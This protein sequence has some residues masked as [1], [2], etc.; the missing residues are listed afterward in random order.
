MTD[1]IRGIIHH[2]PKWLSRLACVPLWKFLVHALMNEETEA[3][4]N[5]T[6]APGEGERRAQRGYV[7]QYDLAAQVI[8]EA[9]AAGRLQWVGVADRKAGIFDDVVL[10]L[11]DRI[12]AHQVKTS[13]D[14]EPFNIKTIM[15]GAENLWARMLETRRKLSAGYPDAIIETIY[16]CDD[17]PRTNDNLSAANAPSS[18]AAFI[19]THQAYRLAWTLADWRASHFAGF[20]GELQAASKLSDDAF[21]NVWRN[22]RFLV[23]GQGRSI[24]IP[25]LGS[26]DTR[27]LRELAAL[28]PRLVADRA[29]QDRWL[30]SEILDRLGW[31]DPFDL[32]HGHAFPVD[33]LYQTNATTEDHLQ[34]ILAANTSGYTSLIGPPG[35]GKSTLLASGLL[36][37]PR[38]VVVR[39]LA[40]VPGEG[41]GLGRAEAFDFLN[42][43]VKQ[44]KQQNLGARVVP[45]TE[46]V[47]LREQFEAILL[48]AGERFR[49][50]GIRTVVVVDGLDH[51]PR[52]ERPQR[53]FLQEL[54]L[55]HAVPEGI[56]FVLG[57]QRLDLQDVPPAVI[58]QAGKNGR[59][60]DISPL[61][62]EVVSRLADAAGVPQDVDRG[63]LYTQTDGHPLST[64]YVIEG[65]LN[66]RTPEGREDWLRNGPAYGGDIETFY[67]RAWHDLEQNVAGQRALAY[68]ALAEGPLSTNS[69][70]GIVGARATDDAWQAAK[71]LLVRDHQGG[72][73]IFH[74]SFRLFLR[75]RTGLRHG[76]ADEA[77]VRRRYGELADMARDANQTDSQRW[78]ELRYRARAG[79]HAAVAELARPERFRTQFI[80]GR[81]PGDIRIDIDFG[82]EAARF[83]RRPE[84]VVD[85]VLSRHEINMRAEALGD[86]VFEVLIRLGERRAALGLLDA[87]GVSLTVGKGYELVDAFLN[88]GE[89]P[90]ARKLFHELEPIHKLLGSEALEMRVDDNDLVEWAERALV[91]REPRQFLASIA[92]LRARDEPFGE[93]FDIEDYRTQLKLIAVRGQ[94]MRN[95]ELA[96]EQLREALQIGSEN[97]GLLLYFAAKAAFDGDNDTVALQRLKEGFAHL[98]D[99][100]PNVKQ[101]LAAFAA[102]IGKLDL[103]EAFFVDAPPP[104]LAGRDIAYDVE[105][106]RRVSRQIIT[107]ATLTAWLGRPPTTGDTPQ[108]RLLATYQMRLETIG[109]LLGEGRAGCQPSLEPMQEFRAT[110][111][112]LQRA[113]GDTPHDSER[114]RLDQIMDEMV[115]A[116]VDAAVA[117]GSD[118]FARFTEAMD[119]RLAA[120]AGRLGRSTVRRA[121]AMAAFRHE[122]D[123]GRAELRLAYRACMERTPAE[124]LTEAARTASAFATFGL[125]NRARALVAE[126]H[127]DGL[128]YARPAKKDAQYLVWRDLL[129]RAG[130]E[131]PAGRPDRLRFFGRMLAG[132]AD[133]E[134]DN[135]GS[136]LATTF[137]SEAAQEGPA[138]AKAAA[139]R[140]EEC[141]LITWTDL[142]RGLVSGVVKSRPDLTAAAGV[143]FGRTALPFGGEYSKSIYPA[144]ILAAPDEQ[145]ETVVRHAATCIEVD[146]HTTR[147]IICL[148]EVVTAAAARGFDH[149]AEA[150]AR[151][152]AEL[153]PPRSGDSPEDPF[154]LVRTLEGITETLRQVGEK[155]TTYGA[156]RAFQRI[157]PRSD[158]E[159]AK[160]V[161]DRAEVLSADERSIETMAAAA[162]AAGRQQDARTY[163]QNLKQLA[164]ER[165]SWGDGW[166]GGAKQRYHRLNV[167][168]NGDVARRAA[169]DAFVEDLANRREF[170]DYILPDLGNVLELLSPRPTWAETWARLQEHLS[171]FR[172]HRMGDDLEPGI[173]V[174]EGDEHTLADILFRAIDTTSVELTHMARTAAIELSHMPGG[175]AVVA[176]L[177]P[178]LWRAGGYCSLEASQV[179][180][181]CR[182]VISV[183]DAVM[184]FLGEMCDNDDFAIRRL[185]M[186][187]AHGWGQQP[188][189]KRGDLPVIY[190]LELLPNPEAERFEP[191]SGISAT[192][193][194]LYTEDPYSWTWPLED[195]LKITARATGLDLANL[196]MRAAQLMTRMG[197]AVAF[198]PE[199]FALQQSRLRRLSL[200][201]SYR[202]LS[203]SAAFQAMR[204]LVGELFAADA[205][206]PRAIPV[207]LLR[208]AAF[209]R[210]IS[211]LPPAP[212]P[213]GVPAP[214]I[215]DIHASSA[216][217]EWVAQADEDAVKPTVAGNVVLA[218]T[219]IHV[220]RNFRDEWIVEQY[221]GPDT[222]R[223]EEDLFRQLR[224]LP[225]VVVADGAVPMYEGFAPG[226]V[227]HP[228]PVMVG[229]VDL[230]MVMLCPRVAAALGWRPDPRHAFTYFDKSDQVV[231]RTIYWR[232]G[233]ERSR[234]SDADV[235]RYGFVL[236]AREDEAERIR[237]YLSKAQ[238][239]RAWRRTQ[240]NGSEGRSAACG[241]RFETA[242]SSGS[243]AERYAGQRGRCTIPPFTCLST[244]EPYVSSAVVAL[245]R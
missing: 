122:F 52:E 10:G 110:L 232:D 44:L 170:V 106:I 58:D 14:P 2:R 163:L 113:E 131:D 100:P 1:A 198:G 173:G 120:G 207:I 68:V 49:A 129:V 83:L 24:G 60:V 187:L 6:V 204:E 211:T 169:F 99:L 243:A 13:R 19:R 188:R 124:Q 132:L 93:G 138:W 225:R 153:A 23:G 219:A 119:A 197:G 64:R 166:R 241:S 142:V 244:P 88:A 127:E 172:E 48:E 176:A 69:L 16:A 17:Y 206:D 213:Q 101:E 109:R 134:G 201:S 39:Y 183:R 155:D 224:R 158:Y 42:D 162:I 72:W 107:H 237:P 97:R 33:A 230:H 218:A 27:R 160:A 7:P 94:L 116:M 73:S 226:A 146:A 195:A 111:E 85:L 118:H 147:R 67:Q 182:D 80:E 38:A 26:A 126:M 144:L 202:K 238:V 84:L 150:L 28:L 189:V 20:V 181:E 239:S 102:R 18:S 63:Q 228:E 145:L 216:N 221:F 75:T 157:A 11:H 210:C 5:V 179:T 66:A 34:H 9:L 35:S 92:R 74:N 190:D 96:P 222:C 50:E 40:F 231:A 193:S 32:R 62:R 36:P 87:E 82:F 151:W 186:T 167:A 59:R 154:F 159:A 208:A 136:R 149:G 105:D 123:T 194:G 143:I 22:T 104:T 115:A 56:V 214:G 37:T 148:E 117:L 54:P 185:A 240:R 212:R 25:A 55:P 199:A 175:G 178:R 57:T 114:W 77:G 3:V 8:Y 130:Q 4:S 79:D 78:M 89:L 53:S 177:L 220:R 15:L 108:S 47:E 205:I 209:S 235:F 133:T 86:E 31:R 171:Y 45:G 70:D 192:C 156:V 43:V 191:P 61:S 21:E 233:G 164:D 41:Q 125:E 229:S 51:V 76:V 234:E 91:F 203:N 98:S 95:L 180:W 245:P 137:L 128:G 152:R 161:F 184:P 165:G 12:A 227:V 141:D 174:S 135:A 71:H 236:V 121:Y 242:A 140:V 223:A 90:E 196:R 217:T 46:L 139:D 112:F 65:L 168:L 30:L 81:D 29:N 103:A 215:V 200:H